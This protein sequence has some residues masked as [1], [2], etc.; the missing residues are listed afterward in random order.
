[1]RRWT[2][3]EITYLE[4]HAQDG[5][6]AIA[7]ALGR[8]VTSVQWQASQYGISL[9][10]RWLCANCGR[11]VHKP[12]SERTGWCMACSKAKVRERLESELRDIREEIEREKDED[13]RRQAIYSQKNRLRNTL[14]ETTNR[15]SKGEKQRKKGKEER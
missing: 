13:R 8:S 15:S 3:R 9:R 10:R 14:K 5:A 6:D 12:L 4:Q 7:A 2:A 1:M 11:W